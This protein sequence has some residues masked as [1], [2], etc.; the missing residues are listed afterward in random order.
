MI[1]AQAGQFRDAQE[2][3]LNESRAFATRWFE[4]RQ[5]DTRSAIETAGDIA[6]K[7]P[8]DPAAALRSVTEWQAHAMERMTE[9]F[10]D[11]LELC[12][13]CAGHLARVEIAASEEIAKSAGSTKRRKDNIPV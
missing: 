1:G 7:G 2:N 4:R 5:A 6:A 3:I 8:S 9:D 12:S 13:D 10:R 11:W